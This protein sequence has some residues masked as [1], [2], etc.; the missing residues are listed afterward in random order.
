VVSLGDSFHDRRGAELLEP[1]LAEQVRRLTAGFEWL[2]I[3][4]NHDPDP[5]AELGGVSLPEL[6]LRSLFFRHAPCG[7][8]GEVAGHLHPKAR[9]V[10]TRLRVSRPCYVSD[11]QRLVLP[12]FGSYTGGLDVMHP[13][14]AGL[15]P[16]GFAAML[17]GTARVFRVPHDRLEPWLSQTGAG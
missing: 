10:G 1:E 7:E 12:A 17:L 13:T 14:I 5:P 4:G 2:W 11:G 9:L 16:S 15:F 6:R 8:A 3:R